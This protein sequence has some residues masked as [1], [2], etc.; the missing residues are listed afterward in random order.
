MDSDD[1]MR[2]ANDADS[3]DDFY[4]G[5]TAAENSDNDDDVVDYGYIENDSD[6]DVETLAFNRHQV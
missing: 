2:D 6:A 4:S 3:L 5:D 1:D